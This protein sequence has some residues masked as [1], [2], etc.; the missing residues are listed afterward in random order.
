MTT[1]YQA[2]NAIYDKFDKI[3]VLAE[4]RVIYYGPRSL[5]RSYFENMGFVCPKGANIAD[6]L[7]SVT[8]HTERIVR[9]GMEG[10]VPSTP[11]EFEVAYHSSKIYT[12]M[13]ENI[14]PPEKLQN[15][16][17]DLIMAVN[18]E[19]KQPHIPRSH[20]PY[21]TKLTDQIISC[22]I[23]YVTLFNHDRSGSNVS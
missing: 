3:L 7:T 16:K 1:T 14:E 18:K 23:R 13:M 5:G 4:G 2:G 11:D 19:K 9:E 22:S 10:K 20:S 21:T 6:F 15:E 17:D 12:D 8:V